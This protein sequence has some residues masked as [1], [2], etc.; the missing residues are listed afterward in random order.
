MAGAV[1][2]RRRENKGVWRRYRDIVQ[3]RGDLRLLRTK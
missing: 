2:Q 1:R 3:V